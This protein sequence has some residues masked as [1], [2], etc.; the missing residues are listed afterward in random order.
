MSS[1]RGSVRV[2]AEHLAQAVGPLDRA[3]RDPETFAMTMRRVGWEAAEPPASYAAVADAAA[4]AVQAARALADEPELVEVLA[5]IDAAGAVYRALDGLDE[6]PAGIDPDAFLGVIGRELFE[7]LLSEHL[8]TRLPGAFWALQAIGVISFEAQAPTA[9]RPAFVRTRFDWEALPETLSDPAAIPVQ[10]LGWGTS[11]FDF[12]RV[13]E[14]VSELVAGIGI[15]GSIDRVDPALG[16][17]IQ[18]QATGQPDRGVYRGFTVRLFEN[19]AD[20]EPVALTATELPAEG[21]ALPGMLIL[22]KVPSGIDPELDLGQGWTFAVRPGADLSEQLGVV[23]RPGET[24]LRYPFA[25]GR[26]LPAEGFGASL[27]S[28]SETPRVLLGEPGGI[29]L[30]IAGLTF[31]LD[32]DRDAD[33]LELTLGLEPEG[34]ALVLSAASLDGFLGSVLGAAEARIDVPFGLSWSNRTGLGLATGAGFEIALHPEISVGG[35]HIDRVDL[36]LALGTGAAPELALRAAAAVSGELGPV[37]FAADALGAELPLVFV[38]GNAGPLDIGFRIVLPSGLGIGVDVAGVV[39][40][41]GFLDI[42]PAA[43]RYAGIGE[44]DILGVGL[45]AVGIVETKIPSAPGE[46]SMFLSLAAQFT[47]IQLGFGFTLNGVGGLVGI[48]RGLDDDALGE[49]VRTGSLDAILFPEDPIAN[50]TRILA[51]I[52]A[53][54]PAARGQYVFGPIVKIGWGTPTLVEIDAGVAIQLPEPLTISLLGALSAVLPREQTPILELHVNFAGTLNLTEGTLKI[55]ASLHGSQVAGF[56]ITGDMAVR[57]SF[58]DNP[59]FLVSFGGFH[60]KFVPPDDFPELDPVGVSLDTGE[61]LRV[62]VGG[63]FAL[64]SNTVQFGARADLWAGAEGFSIEGGTSFDTLIY[65]EPFSFSI[66]LRLWVSVI[67]AGTE[68]L[69]VLLAGRLS[70]PNP[71][72]VAGVAEFR[73][74]GLEKRFE[75]DESF[76]ELANEGPPESADPA[77]LV[78]DA[79]KLEDAWTAVAP[80]GADPVVVTDAEDT[81]ALHPSGRVQV[82]QRLLPLDV[83]IE[84]YGNAEIVGRDLVSVEAVGFADDDVEDVTENFASAQYFLLDED[85][86]LTA[87]SFTPMKAGLVM[88]G[89]GADAPDAREAIFDHEIAYRDPNGRD[90]EP[91]SV[92]GVVSARDEAMTRALGA[93]SPPSVRYSVAE[94]RFLVTN[95]DTGRSTGAVPSSG[96]DFFAARM[97]RGAAESIL[98]PT[99]ET[100]LIS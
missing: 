67:A 36:A 4:E 10:V 72:K 53:V 68:L 6:A 16:D 45:V 89:S 65:F 79:L 46:W 27:T 44:L 59:G 18:A 69:G 82:T 33:E 2:L 98:V 66:R 48:D 19:P 51:E 25:P 70:G 55:D 85:E 39:S 1:D 58:L 94:P 20:F 30:E 63:Y 40:G 24:A 29:R 5:V 22:P 90:D 11:E 15:S 93:A 50:A 75:V 31:S 99:Y 49:A 81:R 35:V 32:L 71:W 14:V 84:C 78:R 7:Y 21:S 100:E 86:K 47:G 88:G 61:A 43:G 76:G 83:T 80:P 96:V 41:G 92:V 9:D 87:P 23:L 28:T 42:D 34:L 3:L 97:A 54:F 77:Q 64:T 26:E 62:S 74:L 73:I 57:S 12:S 38:D 8:A 56:L 95:P 91:G 13:A 60:P 37:A 17:A 52:D